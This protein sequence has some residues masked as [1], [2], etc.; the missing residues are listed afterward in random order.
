[1]TFGCVRILLALFPQ[2]MA[3]LNIPHIDA[4]PIDGFV[5]G[6][7]LLV[8]FATGL[9]CGM[10][11]AFDLMRSATGASL[12]ESSRKLACAR[13]SGRLRNVLTGVEVAV[14]V[15]LLV[16]AGLMLKSFAH[17]LGGNLGIKPDHVLTLRLVLPAD[18]YRSAS[19]LLPF[20]DELLAR[21]RSLPGVIGRYRDVSSTKRMV[22]NSH[23]DSQWRK[24]C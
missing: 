16:A 8:C 7:A 10:L 4:I 19:T 9:L 21:L 3:N 6:F 17:L 5:L 18:N 14:S 23:C 22:G 12:K 20:S 13:S 2:N 24:P 11:P 15:V 1:L